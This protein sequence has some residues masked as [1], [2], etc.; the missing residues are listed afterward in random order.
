M[1]QIGNGEL[2]GVTDTGRNVEDR[3]AVIVRLQD[4]IGEIK[5]ILHVP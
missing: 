3:G 1:E 2:K 5:D 4:D